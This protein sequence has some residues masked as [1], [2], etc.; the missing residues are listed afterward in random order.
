MIE[1]PLN[2]VHIEVGEIRGTDA[3][4]AAQTGKA[5]RITVPVAL[6]I[7]MAEEAANEIGNALRGVN[8][9]IASTLPPEPEIKK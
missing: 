1:I 2:N 5:L 9:H 8:L 3:E 7:P 6:I 4:G